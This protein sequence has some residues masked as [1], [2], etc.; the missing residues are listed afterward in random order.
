MVSENSARL[1]ETN[2]PKKSPLDSTCEVFR[3]GELCL[4]V[5]ERQIIQRK[6]SQLV[7]GFV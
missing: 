5:A 1:K 7:L 3:P 2:Q 4:N 6:G